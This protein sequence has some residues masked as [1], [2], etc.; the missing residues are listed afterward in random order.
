MGRDDQ[1]KST[2]LAEDHRPC[3]VVLRRNAQQLR[4]ARP[5]DLSPGRIP[6]FPSPCTRRGLKGRRITAQ[7]ESLGSPG[8]NPW[9]PPARIPG[10]PRRESLGSPGENPWVPRP[11][12]VPGAACKAAGS[13]PRENPWVPPARIPGFPRD[14][15]V[16]NHRNIGPIRLIRPIGPMPLVRHKPTTQARILFLRPTST[17]SPKLGFASSHRHCVTSLHAKGL[18]VSVE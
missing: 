2:L 10:F 9:V 15:V 17:Q 11:P 8:E 1:S 13:Q 18:G 14:D 5:Q 3:G 7:G 12:P 6:G 16:A 4:P